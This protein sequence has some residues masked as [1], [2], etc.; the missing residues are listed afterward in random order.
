M[1][2]ITIKSSEDI[3]HT[4]LLHGL[5]RA[6]IHYPFLV[7]NILVSP[8][9]FP[10]GANISL[11]FLGDKRNP[12]CVKYHKQTLVI[13]Y[14]EKRVTSDIVTSFAQAVVEEYLALRHPYVACEWHGKSLTIHPS[15][16]IWA[17]IV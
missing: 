11:S 12:L 9:P 5:K 10:T 3:H 4:C 17:E 2:A 13:V 14:D 15:G 7:T 8:P 1:L 16:E 6:Y